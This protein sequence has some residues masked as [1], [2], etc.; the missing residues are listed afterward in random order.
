MR[1]SLSELIRWADI[2]AAKDISARLKSF[3]LRVE[4][5]QRESQFGVLPA[6]KPT[7]V[8]AKKEAPTKEWEAQPLAKTPR[9]SV[10]SSSWLRNCQSGRSTLSRREGSG[11]ENPPCT[12][13]DD[14]CLGMAL[15]P[16]KLS[17]GSVAEG[18]R[19]KHRGKHIYR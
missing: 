18:C 16:A 13:G 2:P 14:R 3:C 17:A 1:L 4:G 6:S 15:C 5:L 8:S 9:E 7:I 12:L 19:D 11:K 10:A